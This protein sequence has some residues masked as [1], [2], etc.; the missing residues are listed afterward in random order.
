MRARLDNR[1]ER[2]RARHE[3]ARLVMGTIFLLK[4]NLNKF[5][6]NMYN[7]ISTWSCAVGR[8]RKIFNEVVYHNIHVL[9]DCG[10]ISRIEID[11]TDN[12][13]VRHGASDFLYSCLN[14]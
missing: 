5:E 9:N 2:A 10:G 6:T 12:K 3:L 14:A 4:N 11:N 8:K 13:Q 7:T 1:I